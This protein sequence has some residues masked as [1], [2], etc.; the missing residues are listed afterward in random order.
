MNVK[1]RTALERFI[2]FSAICLI[3]TH[4]NSCNIINFDL[5]LLKTAKVNCL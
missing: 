3:G 2:S 5:S 4:T 1:M